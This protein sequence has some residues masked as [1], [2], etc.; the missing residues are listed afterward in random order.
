MTACRI[1]VV[2]SVV[3]PELSFDTGGSAASGRAALSGG[4]SEA[5]PMSLP[6]AVGNSG[7]PF[8]GIEAVRLARLARPAYGS[9]PSLEQ[10]QKWLQLIAL[11]QP[12]RV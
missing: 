12:S 2:W 4:C 3:K 6:R 10:K 5:P 1:G 9:G 7:N 11:K 8:V